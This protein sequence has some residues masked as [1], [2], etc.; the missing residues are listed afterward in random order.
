MLLLAL[1]AVITSFLSNNTKLSSDIHQ[2]F[3]IGILGEPLFEN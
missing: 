3:T 2:A 1:D